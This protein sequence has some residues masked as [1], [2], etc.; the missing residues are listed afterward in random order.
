MYIYHKYWWDMAQRVVGFELS[1]H[2][3]AWLLTVQCLYLHL[4]VLSVGARTGQ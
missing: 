1:L 4:L 2:D 3:P